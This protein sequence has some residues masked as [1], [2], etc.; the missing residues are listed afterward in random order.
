MNFDLF[1]DSEYFSQINNSKVF[2]WSSILIRVIIA[3]GE[4]AMTPACYA[5]ASQQLGERHQVGINYLFFL[6]FFQAGGSTQ[7][8]MG[9]QI[10]VDQ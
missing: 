7:S 8:D 3:V 2:F 6:D 9:T 4:S 10:P 1:F 5:L